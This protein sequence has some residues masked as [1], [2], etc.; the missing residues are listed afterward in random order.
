MHCRIEGPDAYDIFT[1]FEERWQKASQPHG[2][3]KLIK[4][5]SHDD[6]LLKIERV[7]GI[8][9]IAE[10]PCQTQ[11]DPEGW[12]LQVQ[13]MSIFYWSWIFQF[14]ISFFYFLGLKFVTIEGF[15]FN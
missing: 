2:L 9:G 1:N 15:S 8:I 3:E 7:P 10:F 11:N 14:M 6:A 4:A 13:L 5:S 12:H